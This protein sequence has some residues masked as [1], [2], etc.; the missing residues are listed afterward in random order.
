MQ[1]VHYTERSRPPPPLPPAAAGQ[2]VSASFHSLEQLDTD[3]GPAL[4]YAFLSPI[5]DSVSKEGY[6]AAEFDPRQLSAALERVPYPVAALGGITENNIQETKSL[7]FAGVALI[8]SV[9]QAEDPV[10]AFECMQ[11]ACSRCWTTEF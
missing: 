9:W 3:W 7:G 10:G 1:G 8:G 5:F 6:N 11:E 2:S 4:S